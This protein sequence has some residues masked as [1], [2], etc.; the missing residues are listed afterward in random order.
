MSSGACAQCVWNEDAKEPIIIRLF[1]AK[2]PIKIRNVIGS[3]HT[4]R[5]ERRREPKRENGKERESNER[6]I[7]I[8]IESERE[9]Q[10]E[11]RRDRESANF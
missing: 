5:L 11:T 8:E 6:K 4:V 10:K 7:E 9:G 3:L 2:W 1:C